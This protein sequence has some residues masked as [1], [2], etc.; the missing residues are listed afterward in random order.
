MLLWKAVTI[1]NCAACHV[2]SHGLCYMWI[3]VKRPLN[4]NACPLPDNIFVKLFDRHTTY[5]YL[6]V[7]LKSFV[8]SGAFWLGR[9]ATERATISQ[10]INSILFFVVWLLINRNKKPTPASRPAG[11]PRQNF[12]SREAKS[13]ALRSRAQPLL[14]VLLELR[15]NL[16]WRSICNLSCT[17][18][19]VAANKNHTIF[20]GRARDTGKLKG[21]GNFWLPRRRKECAPEFKTLADYVIPRKKIGC[22]WSFLLLEE[23]KIYL[24]WN[25]C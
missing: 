9:E 10:V 5:C 23:F 17:W 21:R 2:H 11:P 14:F 19:E 13:C 15:C 20:S 16:C 12:Q 3:H 24:S 25:I 7:D 18:F 4:I 1:E 8:A 22:V 6:Q